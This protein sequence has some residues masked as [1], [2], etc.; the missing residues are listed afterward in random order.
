MVKLNPMKVLGIDHGTKRIGLAMSDGLKKFAWDFG[1]IDNGVFKPTSK[2]DAIAFDFKSFSKAGSII[3]MLCVI[4]KTHT[5]S[6]VVFGLPL[7]LDGT[8]SPQ[9]AK[10]K[11]FAGKFMEECEEQGLEIEFHF[12]DERL[13]S[14]EAENIKTEKDEID[15]ISAKI[16]LQGYLDKIGRN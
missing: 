16:I 7:M 4:C 13:T 8:E 11:E 15:V 12:E 14:V 6:E 5:V 10:V 2:E 9:T 3:N 1:L